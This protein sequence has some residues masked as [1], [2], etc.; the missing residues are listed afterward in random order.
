MNKIWTN[1]TVKSPE[2]GNLLY[3]HTHTHTPRSCVELFLGKRILT[4]ILNR[5]RFIYCRPLHCS[6]SHLCTALTERVCIIFCEL[7]SNCKGDG[8]FSLIFRLPVNSGKTVSSKNQ[9]MKSKSEEGF[10]THEKSFCIKELS[11]ANF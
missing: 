2:F 6:A 7:L 4:G 11:N 1:S 8:H 5:Y 10:S 3:T 9:P